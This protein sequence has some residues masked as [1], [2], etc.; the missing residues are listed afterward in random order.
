APDLDGVL[1]RTGAAQRDRL[2]AD[3]DGVPRADRRARRAAEPGD[4]LAARIDDGEVEIAVARPGGYDLHIAAQAAVVR[5]GPLEQRVD[6]GGRLRFR[7]RQQII[8]QRLLTGAGRAPNGLDHA[9]GVAGVLLGQRLQRPARERRL[10]GPA[11]QARQPSLRLG[12]VGAD[13]DDAAQHADG[14]VAIATAGG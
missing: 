11:P 14:A 13:L 10:S 7:R 3:A 2:A 9:R 4:A 8:G 1:A 12:V 5:I 6:G